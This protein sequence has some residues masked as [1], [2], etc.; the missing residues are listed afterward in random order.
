MTPNRFNNLEKEEKS[1]GIT[2]PDIKLYY[3][4]TINKTVWYQ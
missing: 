4:A 2:I 3:K 1:M